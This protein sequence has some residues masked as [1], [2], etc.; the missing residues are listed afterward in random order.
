MINNLKIQSDDIVELTKARIEFNILMESE[1][2]AK[3]AKGGRGNYVT[4]EALQDATKPLLSKVGL[5]MEQSTLPSNGSEYLITTLYHKSGQ[6]SR[7]VGFLYKE[8]DNMTADDAQEYGKIMTYKQR[9][10]W[11]SMLC[12]GRGSEDAE[13]SGNAIPLTVAHQNEILKIIK[14]DK[15]AI[16]ELCRVLNISSFSIMSDKD[17]EKIK[18]LAIELAKMW[19]I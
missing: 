19:G 13:K 11:R 15:E 17:F 8:V 12:L 18:K 7:S 4:I 16:A 10:Q 3:D 1:E 14:D 5:S 6:F 2:L 9:Y